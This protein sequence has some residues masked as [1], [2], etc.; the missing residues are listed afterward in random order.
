EFNVQVLQTVTPPPAVD[1]R[2]TVGIGTDDNVQLTSPPCNNRWWAG[3]SQTVGGDVGDTIAVD[4]AR[5][6]SRTFQ[7]CA[8]GSRGQLSGNKS[9]VARWAN[10]I[11]S[12]AAH[13]AAHNYGLS[14]E[15]GGPHSANEDAWV[16][17]LMRE[18]R[19]TYSWKDR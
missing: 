19:G 1:R 8:G 15:D 9:T 16:N 14:H 2:N 11:G 17:H 10:A 13:E 5:V 7:T 3:Q 12:T 18:G 6:W 4:Y